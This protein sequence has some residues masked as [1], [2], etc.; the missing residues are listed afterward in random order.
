MPQAGSGPAIANAATSASSRTSVQPPA[1][2]RPA[3]T[4]DASG[5]A[6]AAIADAAEAI[7]S[8]VADIESQF[9]SYLPHAER[10]S[11]ACEVLRRETADAEAAAHAPWLPRLLPLLATRTGPVVIPLFEWMED[12]AERVPDGW[13][14]LDAMLGAQ[15]GAL[16]LRAAR[17]L[18]RAIEAKRAAVSPSMIETFA[19]LME[20]E[21]SGLSTEEGLRETARVL[22][23]AVS[24][25]ELLVQRVSP[26][27]QRLAARVLDLDGTPP[28]DRVVRRVLGEEAAALLAPYLMFTRATHMDLVALVP[29]ARSPAVLASF[30][31]AGEILGERVMGDTVAALGW[32]RVNFGIEV[33]PV[34]GVSLSDAFPFLLSEEEASLIA[35]VPGA[36]R[37]FER[38]L[39]I[40]AGGGA[41]GE[42]NGH[43]RGPTPT[44]KSDTLSRFRAYNVVH[45]DLLN[46]ILDV[47]PLTRSRLDVIL[48]KTARLVSDFE[49]LFG[50][51]SDRATR[52]EAETLV[53]V[54]ADLR[55]RILEAL[56][57]AATDPL[58]MDVC[59][60]VQPFEDPQAPGDIRTLHGL[61]RYLHQRGLKL[62]F[63]LIGTGP[64]TTKTV[65][66]AVVAPDRTIEVGRHI[67]FIDLE[68]APVSGP[69]PAIPHPVR[70]VADAFARQML[71]AQPIPSHVRVFC[72]GTEVHYFARFRNHPA[73]I[74]IDY[75]PPLRG[76]MIDL[77][78]LGVSNNELDV[79]PR[80]S[81]D[82]IRRFFHHLDFIV[83]IDATSIHARYDKERAVT[84]D[85]L[86]RNAGLLFH[87]VPYL[88]DVDWTIGSLQMSD[89]ARDVVAEAWATF[90]GRWGVLP[91]RQFMTKD[92]AAI[93][94]GLMMGPEGV[95]EVRWNAQ[96][97]Y[98]DRFTGEA[99]AEAAAAL[100]DLV[101][102]L[103]VEPASPVTRADLQ[104]QLVLDARV[105]AP[106]RAA[107]SRGAI[108]S[109]PS[110]LR[111][112]P[113]GQFARVHEVEKL[114]A[115][116]EADAD[117]IG[118]A[119]HLAQV[120]PLIERHVRFRTS[121]SL[122]GF[123]VEHGRVPLGDT[124][125]TLCV[126]R[127][128]MGMPRLACATED[129]FW[130]KRRQGG[131]DEWEEHAGLTPEAVM[132]LLRRHNVLGA[133]PEPLAMDGAS[134]A[135]ELRRT[136]HAPR[137]SA[138]LGHCEGERIAEGVGAS[139]GRAAGLARL[140]AACRDPRDLQG[141]VLVAAGLDPRDAPCL[142]SVAAVVATGGGILSHLGL[143]AVESGT[144]AIIVDGRWET[145][146]RGATVLT[147]DTEDFDSRE[148]HIGA[149]RLVERHHVREIGHEI[150]DG[151][152]VVVDADQGTLTL[153][154]S[155]PATLALHEALRQHAAACERLERAGDDEVLVA[156]GHH[157]RTRHQV[158]KAIARVTDPAVVRF[159]AQEI[160]LAPAWAATDRA[161][162]DGV[163][164]LRQMT[165]REATAGAAR[166]AMRDVTTR[167][168]GRVREARAQAI[169]HIPMAATAHDVLAL[170]LSVLRLHD[171]LT[172]IAAALEEGGLDPGIVSASG[173]R[174]L[175]VVACAR[176]LGLRVDLARSLGDELRAGGRRARQL[177]L[178]RVEQVLGIE[179]P[180]PQGRGGR[181][182]G[183]GERGQGIG[184]KEEARAR[185]QPPYVITARDGGIE[186]EA[187]AGA[188]AA[189][190]AEAARVLGEQAVPPWFAVTDGAFQEVL[191]SPVS[192]ADGA[193]TLRAAIES[194][195]RD[196]AASS[197]AR[198]EAIRRRFE[199]LTL[200]PP[201]AGAVTEAYRA[202]GDDCYVAVRSSASDEDTEHASR[203]GQFD[204]F[205]FVRGEAP[206]VDH[207]KLAWSGLWTERALAN[208]AFPAGTA[209]A[210]HCGIVIQRMVQSRVSGVMQTVNA[211]Q[212]RPLEIVVNVGLG[213]GEGIVSGAVA[214]DLVT[215]SKGEPGDLA[216]RFH[217]LT[218]DKRQRV[219]FDARFGQGTIRTDTLAHQ[220]L[221]PAL[222]YPELRE[223]VDV[224]L[225][226]ERAY[227]HPVDIE[228]GFEDA[229]LRV[230]QVRPVPASLA[231]WHETRDR[232][233][234]APQA[235]EKE[236]Q[237]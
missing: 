171:T 132:T 112:R 95:R 236:R 135:V 37:V 82:A 115:L 155:E 166:T 58:P 76:G 225:R 216:L 105:L 81:L 84:L 38:H 89:E 185:V 103:G 8:A 159:A 204:T 4:A 219:V 140:G 125:V 190:L 198:A 218:A 224:A 11:A 167:L 162:R 86:H 134:L 192:A 47:A 208:A 122:N 64:K 153:L 151:D 189:N 109:S 138:P 201:L 179:T 120:V 195:L 63:A 74:R 48:E 1:P 52:V 12:L 180:G 148:R 237:P 5:D 28:P 176:L 202:L 65:D 32:P 88:M 40:A 222:E 235:G 133:A 233:P 13:P 136:F 217:Y 149:Y 174:D 121:G 160:L 188:K 137:A 33:R 230:L 67:E 211:A 169:R 141:T 68:G 18:A 101:V 170:R 75:S 3:L 221:R 223:L 158:E 111:Q 143:L 196:A 144:P 6:S 17:A 29:A 203:A 106:V 193:P 49:A 53:R 157:L 191:D 173:Q 25:G 30:R 124:A 100:Q 227:G 183:I 22:A 199:G 59:R 85:Q 123:P 90:F 24:I 182:Q 215:V 27:A 163:A 131:E 129:D 54:H 139:P 178:Q 212:S 93:L 19:E 20:R 229:H 61:K 145:T 55:A 177:Q 36:R 34:V 16:Q 10:V 206:V 80:L 91:Y 96:A 146:A 128:A 71:H 62:A 116:I 83:A 220:R 226:V 231:V 175:D 14:I 186:L 164:L 127:D 168:A 197:A 234:L 126:L 209:L 21:G 110:G 42:G 181:G 152:L 150:H 118:D 7:E 184:E 66:L 2:S 69:A 205:L 207:L 187:V 46:E 114:V 70:L 44:A 9:A 73:F 60:L 200:P 214:A 165:G 79:H 45:A 107:L 94:A 102:S 51:S 119:A 213:L 130:W 117:T 56:G 142:L 92:R 161:L 15:D 23:P 77:Q 26:R 87:L 72:Y 228:F 194:I 232:F 108:V 35:G 41:A 104:G 172:R 113:P 156:R 78:Y 210:P 43:A 57:R 50:G 39:V 98:R 99:T 97:P 31:R 154:G 147:C